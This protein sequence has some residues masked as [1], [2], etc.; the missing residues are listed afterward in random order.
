METRYECPKCGTADL[1]PQG[2]SPE[3]SGSC[4]ERMMEQ[5]LVPYPRVWDE[6][7]G[8]ND[9][10]ARVLGL[11]GSCGTT[12]G[13]FSQAVLLRDQIL[14]LRST[15]AMCRSELSGLFSHPNLLSRYK[16]LAPTIRDAG[17]T[18]RYL[19]EYW[20]LWNEVGRLETERDRGLVDEQS[21]VE[22]RRQ[23][24]C[25]TRNL[26]TSM[27]GTETLARA[28]WSRA[29]NM[30]VQEADEVQEADRVQETDVD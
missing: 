29:N 17:Q 27:I 30:R 15:L 23:L 28:R 6:S 11:K 25:V 4:G 14:E 9:Q 21:I 13:L 3:C 2:M 12:R 22:L 5:E 1:A 19:R 26:F 16:D 18:W 24:D 10:L 20:V 7:L 8:H